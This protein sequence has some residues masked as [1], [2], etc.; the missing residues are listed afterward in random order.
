MNTGVQVCQD[1]AFNSFGC[2]LRRGIIG[3]YGDSIFDFLRNHPTVLQ[4]SCTSYLPT[5]SA[6]YNCSTSGSTLVIV[7][8]L[9]DSSHSNGF[10]HG[11]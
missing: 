9:F 7:C 10:A 11:D 4:S 3:P 5:N 1:V 6:G 8:V 2:I